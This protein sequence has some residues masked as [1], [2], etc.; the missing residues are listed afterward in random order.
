MIKIL[1][2][3]TP[4]E[5]LRYKKKYDG[6]LV[7]PCPSCGYESGGSNSSGCI[8]NPKTNTLYCFNSKTVFNGD[9]AAALVTGIITCKDG[10]RKIV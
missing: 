9:E 10:R 8:I 4:E 5:L 7:G 1:S 6:S 2:L 3:F